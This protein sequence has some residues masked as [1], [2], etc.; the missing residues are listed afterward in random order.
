[1]TASCKKDDENT[2]AGFTADQE[3]T[4]DQNQTD[5]EVEDISAMQD[6]L[7]ASN[8]TKLYARVA[9]VD[10]TYTIPFDSCATV[11]IIPK[12]TNP[13]GKISV[14]YG[15]GCQGRDGRYRKGIIEWTFTD[16]IR[17][18]GAVLTTKFISYGVKK[19]NSDSYIMVDN[20]S[21]KI[22]T[23]MSSNEPIPGNTT[24][25]LRRDI[26]MKLIFPDNSTFSFLGTKDLVW[27]LGVLG[28]RWDNVYTMKA[29]SN[30]TGVDR[31][32]RNYTMT[33]NTD[34]VRKASCSLAG[35]FKPVSGKLT[36]THDA[37]T[38][39]VDFGDGTCD[40]SVSVTING[41]I[42]RTRW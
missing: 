31:K 28:Y 42:T 19:T 29:G 32:N 40:N 7:M 22:T 35:V 23:N 2:D 24:F 27:D 12:G 30:L 39:V 4:K 8:E 6:D 18:P 20:A 36:I 13:T 26:G 10:T 21:T 25:Q 17:K 34:V 1:M 38:K 5:N 37:K 9:V 41:K 14:N 11:T 33:V 3:V 15:T 16:R